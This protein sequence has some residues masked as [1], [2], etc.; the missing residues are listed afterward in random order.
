MNEYTYEEISIGQKESFSVTVTEEMLEKFRD[1]TGD[2]NP[3]HN[4]EEYAVSKG[5]P[6]KV[7]YGML[8]ASFLSTLAG[9]YLPGRRSL[10]H[11]VSVKFSKPVYPGDVLTIEG[12]VE[13]K[14]DAY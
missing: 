7:A 3:L 14:T 5:H 8:T 2:I 13:G 12:E 4:D 1:I 10:I 11:E 9:V 6:K